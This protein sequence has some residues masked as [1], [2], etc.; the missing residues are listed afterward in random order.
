MLSSIL[1]QRRASIA[2]TTVTEYSTDLTKNFKKSNKFGE[3]LYPSPIKYRFNSDGFRCDELSLPSKFPII[4]TGC[5]ITEGVGLQFEDTWAHKL[6]QRIRA[7]TNAII[8]YWNLA[9][10]GTGVDTMAHNLYSLATLT[11]PKFIFAHFPP[12]SRRELIYGKGDTW[13]WAPWNTGDNVLDPFC[14]DDFTIQH[15]THRS[16]MLMDSV[17]KISNTVVAYSSWD[18]AGG[19]CI[20]DDS[21]T[22]KHS[23]TVSENF[24]HWIQVQY[25]LDYLDYA[26]DSIHAGPK[27]HDILCEAYWNKIVHLL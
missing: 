13:T 2:N 8:P 9:V 7:H 23:Y 12:F 18:L 26:R 6:L 17:S 3:N 20:G 14:S 5:S 25:S 21:P 15:Q 10:E 22:P 16:L 4:F 27:T 1:S 19:L 24:P 11:K